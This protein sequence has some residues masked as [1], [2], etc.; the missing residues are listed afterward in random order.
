MSENVLSMALDLIGYRNLEAARAHIWASSV[1]E[2]DLDLGLKH[3]NVE[4]SLSFVK[5]R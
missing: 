3:Q 5:T 2:E 4:R 1:L